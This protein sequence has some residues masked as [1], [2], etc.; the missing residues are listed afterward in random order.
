MLEKYKKEIV[1]I[2]L[3]ASILTIIGFF[4]SGGNSQNISGTIIN[5]SNVSQNIGN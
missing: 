2:G 1:I 5:N 4:G 3:I